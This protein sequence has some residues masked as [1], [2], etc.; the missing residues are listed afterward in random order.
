MLLLPLAFVG[1]DIRLNDV[2]PADDSDDDGDL[3]IK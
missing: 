1:A 3:E 2:I